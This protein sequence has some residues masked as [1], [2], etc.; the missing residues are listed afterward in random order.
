M[1]AAALAHALALSLALAA[2]GGAQR[3]GGPPRCAPPFGIPAGFEVTEDLADRFPDRVATRS[4]LEDARGRTLH[5]F[6]GLE[7]EFGEGLPVADDAVPL[8]RGGTAVLL[9]QGRTW[10]LV[11]RTT[12]SCASKAAFGA[13]FRRNAFLRVLREVGV[14]A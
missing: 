4:G 5:R 6:A 10:A 11:W 9:G 2:C 1:R 14:V 3:G 12:G 13:G 8:A 7:G